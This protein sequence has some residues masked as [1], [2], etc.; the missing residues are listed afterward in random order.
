MIQLRPNT[1]VEGGMD[2]SENDGPDWWHRDHPVFT[3]LSGFFSGLAFTLVVPGLFAALL[4]SFL[5][6]HTVTDLFP[7]VLVALVVP[8]VLVARRQSRRFGLYFVLGMVATALVV[9]G[10]GALVVWIL[11][12]TA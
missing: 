6:Q 8:I 10:V 9:V 11:T 2:M 3:P 7:V 5:A 4:E 12:S 1:A